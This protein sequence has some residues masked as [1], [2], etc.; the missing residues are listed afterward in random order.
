M[1]V[2]LCLSGYFNSLTDPSSTGL[3]GY[4]HIK[5]NILDKVDADVFL[6]NWQPELTTEIINLYNPKL[7]VIEEQL[8][9][10]KI[11]RS[12]QLDTLP[13]Q[14]RSPSTIL[15]HFYSVQKSFLLM[16]DSAIDYDI[17]IK[18][19]FDLGRINRQTSGPGLGNSYPVQ[20]INFDP[21]LDMTKMYVAN[22]DYFNDG[23]ADMWF[24]SGY[25]NMIKF[26]N[27][28]QKLINDYFFLDS[29]YMKS[30]NINNISNAIRLYKKFFIDQKLWNIMQ[31]L[32]TTWE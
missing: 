17:I 9:F 19:R 25:E 29:A 32:E 26:T 30:S 28:Y 15:S 31:P 13:E 6:H 22:W 2:A 16:Q 21:T 27:L 14:P 24:Y 11:I 12:R 4:N 20:C 3:D 18:A 8:N 10:S 7:Y 5:K 23:P 1:K